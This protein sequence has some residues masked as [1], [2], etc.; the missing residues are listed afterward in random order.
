MSRG[1][2]TDPYSPAGVPARVRRRTRGLWLLPLALALLFSLHAARA[3]AASAW[4][5]AARHAPGDAALRQR[6]ELCRRARA[7]YPRDPLLAAWAAKQAFYGARDAGARG[8][9]AEA[10]ELHALAAEW[11]E[12]AIRLNPYDGEAVHVRA[13]VLA[14]SSLPAAI[15]LWTRHRERRF[16]DPFSHW[17]LLDLCARAGRVEPAAEALYWLRDTP[18]YRPGL[19][20]YRSAF[21]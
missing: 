12:L 11:S 7:L 1:A 3:A 5:Y 2:D 16:W 19:A 17:M 6:L 8:S 10:D 13:E 20:L 21:R 14:R 4:Y 15:D 9:Q 18:L